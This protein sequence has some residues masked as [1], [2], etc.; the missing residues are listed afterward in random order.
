MDFWKK[1]R[2]SRFLGRS[3]DQNVLHSQRYRVNIRPAGYFFFLKNFLPYQTFHFK[4]FFC[5]TPFL[6]L[7]CLIVRNTFSSRKWFGHLLE[8]TENIELSHPHFEVMIFYF[9]DFGIDVAK[10][11]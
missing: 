9:R 11:Q 5:F 6:L 1:F 8:K 10:Y 2:I 4:L 7:E 3:R